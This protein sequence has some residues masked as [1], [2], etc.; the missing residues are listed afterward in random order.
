MAG[1]VEL[2]SVIEI[3]PAFAG[4]RGLEVAIQIAVRLLSS[5]D[6]GDGGIGH[7]LQTGIGGAAKFPAHRLQPLVHVGISKP[8]A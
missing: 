1:A 3:G 8:V 2:V 7:L 4:G 5:F 6:L